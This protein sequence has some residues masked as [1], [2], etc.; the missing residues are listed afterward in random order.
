[1]MAAARKRNPAVSGLIALVVLGLVVAAVAFR[2][3]LPIV[4]GGTTYTA[5]FSEAAGMNAG[6]EV[7]VAGVRAGA[8]QGITLDGDHVVVSFRVKDTWVGDK[9]MAA[10][11]I[12]TLLGQK[13]L[14]LDPQGTQKANPDVA[15]PRDRTVAPYDV[16][17]AFSGLSNTLGDI[18]T[19]QLAQSFTVLSQAFQG[20]PASARGALDGVT[21]LSQT[22]SSRDKELAS[23]LDA[24]K[25][26]SKI[27]ADR[28]V[29]FA[30][31]LKDGSVLLSALNDRR[32]A[33]AALLTNTQ[34]LSVQLVGLVNDNRAQLGPVLSNL[35]GV[36][37]T[38]VN[39]LSNI[40][41][42]LALLVPFYRLF[43]NSIGN[44]R[45]FDSIVSNLLGPVNDLTGARAT[46]GTSQAGGN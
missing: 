33:I 12:K 25:Q 34:T 42:G 41:T 23:L 4:G 36:V 29:E 19:G 3:N 6:D 7:R 45:W 22:I 9:T 1:M 21:R 31:L 20:T 39:N 28:N 2:Q 15:I 32:D 40:D 43:N 27:L 16:I 37:N 24:S 5:D 38:L 44:G 8:V 18:N 14:E 30:A 26:T 10:I 11:K 13:Y 46:P 17:E 35:Q